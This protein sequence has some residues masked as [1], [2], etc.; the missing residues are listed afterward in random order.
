MVVW[1]IF[2]FHPEKLGKISIWTHIFQMGWNHQPVIIHLLSGSLSLFDGDSLP[3]TMNK[4]LLKRDQFTN[5]F[6]SSKFAIFKGTRWWQ[7][8]HLSYFHPKTWG[9]DPIWRQYFSNGLGWD[10]QR[11]QQLAGDF[12]W[13]K[14][15]PWICD[16]S[17]S[18]DLR[19]R[20]QKSSPN[21][22]VSLMVMNPM[23]S[24]SVKRHI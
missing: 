17:R 2:Y 22:V 13:L 3:P 19:F 14:R 23:G 9:E 10:H 21:K 18:L 11:F 16:S 4:C 1:N 24:Q 8:K 20:N 15:Y 6:S 5:E 7:L 12:E